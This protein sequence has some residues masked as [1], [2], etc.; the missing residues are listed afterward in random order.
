M[1]QQPPKSS[2]ARS[3]RRSVGQSVMELISFCSQEGTRLLPCEARAAPGRDKS[4]LFPGSTGAEE[5]KQGPWGHV[6]PCCCRLLPLSAA[7]AP[8]SALQAAV[9]D[10]AACG[11]ERAAPSGP[12]LHLCH[13]I[14]ARCCVWLNGT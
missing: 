2:A 1:K 9:G 8:Q 3:A 10:A 7:P 5:V 14:R 11:S 6:F 13:S 12:R 4:L